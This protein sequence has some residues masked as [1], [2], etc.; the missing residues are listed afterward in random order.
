MTDSF[1]LKHFRL[2][3]VQPLTFQNVFEPY[4]FTLRKLKKE[5][6]QETMRE[7]Q[8]PCRLGNGIEKLNLCVCVCVYLS[9]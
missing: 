2:S 3:P 9:H 7:M 6:P 1:S 4:K 5:Q 8:R